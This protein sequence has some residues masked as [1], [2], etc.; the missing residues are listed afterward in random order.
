MFNFLY[1]RHDLVEDRD[2]YKSVLGFCFD[3][4]AFCCSY[5]NR[6]RCVGIY[7]TCVAYCN[8]YPR[9]SRTFRCPQHRREGSVLF[10]TADPAKL[11]E[12]GEDFYD[13]YFCVGIDMSL[14]ASRRDLKRLEPKC[15]GND[16]VPTC[17]AEFNI[18]IPFRSHYPECQYWDKTNEVWRSDGVKVCAKSIS[19]LP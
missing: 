3:C 10:L 11:D 18:S 1:L 4:S 13:I 8:S 14:A 15:L 7:R 6:A 5:Y 9:L 2:V 16:N 17:V 19:H 12:L